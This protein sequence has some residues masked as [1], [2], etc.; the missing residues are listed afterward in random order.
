MVARDTD[1][2]DLQFVYMVF[3]CSSDPL[4]STSSKKNHC[5]GDLEQCFNTCFISSE[6][7]V[8]VG[9]GE[10]P[11]YLPLTQN[12]EFHRIVFTRDYFASA[13]HEVAH[14][15]VAG[16]ERRKLPDYGYWYAPDG[17]SALQQ[18][19]FER[20]EVKPQAMEWIFSVACDYRFRVSADNLAAGLGASDGFKAN[21]FEQARHYC[22]NGLPRRAK[23]FTLALAAHY[24]VENPFNLANYRLDRL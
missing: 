15:C 14:W 24:G 19:E 23:E 4:I 13:L 20:V 7:T 6:K 21:I 12:D 16:A 17:R 1:L 8:L 5:S 11:E 10:E 18:A 9:G 3:I 22:V 2:S